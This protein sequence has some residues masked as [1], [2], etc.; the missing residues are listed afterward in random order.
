MPTTRDDLIADWRKRLAEAS[1]VS[2]EPSSRQ[3]WLTRLRIRLYQFLLSLYGDGSWHVADVPNTSD[4]QQST[5]NQLDEPITWQG[6]PAKDISAIR[7]VLSSVADARP[8]PNVPGSFAEG[9]GPDAW[10]VMATY[11]SGI[12]PYRCA[13]LL[14]S[15]TISARWVNRRDDVTVEVRAKDEAIAA[16]VMQTNIDWLRRFDRFVVPSRPLCGDHLATS[17]YRFT[18]WLDEWS[19]TLITIFHFLLVVPLS[20][21]WAAVM[22]GI[23]SAQYDGM[24]LRDDLFEDYYWLS[25]RSLFLLAVVVTWLRLHW[26]SR[27]TQTNLRTARSATPPWSNALRE[28][29]HTED[30]S[31][32]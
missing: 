4:R 32:H 23:K 9:A 31:P 26:R 25:L 8:T 24:N 16:Q 1:A 17:A 7:A 29:A 11:K 3:A 21:L 28:N 27:I 14:Q 30:P 6:K 13:S 19:F 10:I 5:A 15:R 18:L 20:Y 22:S 2:A 12:D